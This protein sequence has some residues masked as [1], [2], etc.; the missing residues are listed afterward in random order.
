MDNRF[1][2]ATL[3][4]KVNKSGGYSHTFEIAK[5]DEKRF[6]AIAKVSKNILSK[7]GDEGQLLTWYWTADVLDCAE[8]INN[9]QLYVTK[10]GNLRVKS[11]FE[12]KQKRELTQAQDAEQKLAMFKALGLSK[13]D[14]LKHMFGSSIAPTANVAPQQV[15]QATP[16]E[17]IENIM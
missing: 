1:F 14:V 10:A 8:H 9:E 5:E 2:N 12:A 13:E 3:L 15:A 6:E 4:M 7:R 11:V 16:V 17:E